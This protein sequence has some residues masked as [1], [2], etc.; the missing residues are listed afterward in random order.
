MCEPHSC[1]RPALTV[2]S[3]P[4]DPGRRT[5]PL[6]PKRTRRAQSCDKL[7]PDRRRPPDSTGARGV[8]ERVVPLPT[9]PSDAVSPH[10]VAGSP[11]PG[12]RAPWICPHQE[13]VNQEPTDSGCCTL[14]CPPLD[15]CLTRTQT[16]PP[17][18]PT[19][20]GPSASHCPTGSGWQ[21]EA[22]GAGVRDRKGGSD[23]ERGKLPM[24]CLLC[25]A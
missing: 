25:R 5:A 12:N 18:A 4:P 2:I 1:A 17:P 14:P 13:P 21:D 22:W 19:P 24:P 11:C 10:G 15:M 8:G 20:P 16:T 3:G 7:E 6:K 23:L 9:H